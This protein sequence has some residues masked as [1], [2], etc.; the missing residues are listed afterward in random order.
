MEEGC[1]EDIICG[2]CISEKHLKHEILHIKIYSTRK[3][4]ELKRNLDKHQTISKQIKEREEKI[5]MG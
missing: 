2:L 3:G 4:Q 1:H 5:I